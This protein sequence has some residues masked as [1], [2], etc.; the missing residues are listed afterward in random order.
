MKLSLVGT[1]M[2]RLGYD[3][4]MVGMVRRNTFVMTVKVNYLAYVET[5]TSRYGVFCLLTRQPYSVTTLTTDNQM[6]QLLL[7]SF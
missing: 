5:A 2:H 7:S 3:I 1:G 4:G 6:L